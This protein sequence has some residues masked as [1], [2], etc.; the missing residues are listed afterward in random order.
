MSKLL[1]FTDGSVHVQ[2]GIGYGAFIFVADENL[3][4]KELKEKIH[5]VR[6]E[7]TS[8]TKMELQVFLYATNALNENNNKL[9][10]YTDS[11]N[12]SELRTRRAKLEEN[13]FCSKTGKELKNAKLY[14]DF[15]LIVDKFDIKFVK[16]KGHK[17][18]KEKN[19]IDSV[20]TLVDRASR[21]ALRE[22]L[23]KIMS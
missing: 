16:V 13:N 8:S 4:T 17:Q 21:K 14:R 3:D 20:F 10:V 15:F 2:S 23:K 1:L 12:L 11:Q 5:L 9:V 6:F 18:K 7:N 19:S 22:E